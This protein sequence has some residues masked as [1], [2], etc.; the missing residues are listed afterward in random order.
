M[1]VVVVFGA[2]I[3]F[4][5]K[6]FVGLILALNLKVYPFDENSICF[7]VRPPGLVGEHLIVD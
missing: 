2:P 4:A 5:L 7:A 1:V 3:I 6:N